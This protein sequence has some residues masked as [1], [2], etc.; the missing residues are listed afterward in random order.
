MNSMDMKLACN[1]KV[2]CYLI[3]CYSDSSKIL[4][5]FST[6]DKAMCHDVLWLV[7]SMSFKITNK[8][9]L[10]S[11]SVIFLKSKETS[12]IDKRIIDIKMLKSSI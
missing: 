1:L 9:E 12:I 4:V 8:L 6:G 10:C 7:S 3:D 5:G 2:L 11:R